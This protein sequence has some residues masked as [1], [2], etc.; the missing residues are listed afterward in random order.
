MFYVL[1][2][3]IMHFYGNT[4]NTK[5]NPQQS[6]GTNCNYEFYKDG[7]FFFMSQN[8]IITLYWFIIY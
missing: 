3:G 2:L 1:G 6:L 4:L 5:M 8:L 7:V